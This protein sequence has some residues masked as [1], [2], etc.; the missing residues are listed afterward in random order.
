[1]N[2]VNIEQ[3]S[4]IYGEK[5]V[6][7]HASFGIQQGDKNRYRGHQWYRKKHPAE[8]DCGRGGAR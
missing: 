4:K 3:I 7:D 6:F 1:M 8:N 5:T 2:V